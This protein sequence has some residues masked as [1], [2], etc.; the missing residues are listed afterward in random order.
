MAKKKYESD[1]QL[2]GALAAKVQELPENW[3]MCRDVR[4]SW[5]VTEDFHVTKSKGTKVQEI[6]R[7]LTCLR[8]GT[9][10]LEVHHITSWG[11][12]KVSQGY[13]Y[14]HDENGMPYQ[15]HG[16]P[17]GVKPSFIIQGEQY[18]RVMEKLAHAQKGGGKKGSLQAV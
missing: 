14:P 9:L 17:R 5:D 3:L 6:R 16:V 8:C 10:R 11:L 2:A 7:T 4:H 13:K 18:R 12:E 1:E 15:L